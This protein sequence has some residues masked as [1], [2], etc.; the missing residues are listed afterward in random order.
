MRFIAKLGGILAGIMLVVILLP[1]AVAGQPPEPPMVLDGYVYVGGARAEDGTLVEAKIAGEIVKSC[2][3]LTTSGGEKGYYV[4]AF[5]DGQGDEVHLF[6]GGVEADES[7]VDY[8]MGSQT[9]DL[10]I[11]APLYAPPTVAT[12][13]ATSIGAATATLNGSLTNLGSA[14]SIEVS[15]E[16][17]TTTDY[18]NETTPQEVT[19][20]GTFSATLS[21]GLT[22]NTTYH[23]RAKA[24]GQGTGY[25]IDR[26]FTTSTV[27]SPGGGGPAADTTPPVISNVGSCFAGVTETTADICWTTNELSTSQVEY[28]TS[29][30]MLSPLD[31]TRVIDHHVHLTGL[32][33]GTTYNYKTM[34][35]DAAGNL[36]VSDEDTFTTLEAPAAAF[37]SSALRISPTEVNIGEEVTIRVSVTNIGNAAGS[38]EV[39]LKIEDVVVATEEVTLNA[40]ASEEVTFTT[41]KDVAGSYSVVVDGLSGSFTVVAPEVAPLPAAF[42]VSNLSIQPAEVP[43]GEAVTIDVAVTNTGGTEGSYTLVLKINGVK[44]ADRTVTIAAGDTLNIIFP[45]TK[46]AAGS[47]SVTVDGLSGSFTVVAPAVVTNWPLLGG[48]IGAVVIVALLVFFLMFR[49]RAY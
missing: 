2:H 8:E 33:P 25:G 17:G 26:T 21:S 22:A 42:S 39:I 15:F 6:V 36:A 18:G 14:S 3:T 38:Y 23:F 29:P 34:S 4:L 27:P 44:E 35:R 48:I 7:P 37:V 12:E 45:V 40:G 19:E 20:T 5:W 13:A 43:T 24:V 49:R 47:Y 28:W 9:L 16:W 32:T 1:A 11:E 30:S 10:N 31:E 46:E 41:A